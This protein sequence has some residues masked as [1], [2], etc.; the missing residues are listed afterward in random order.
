MRDGPARGATSAA[1]LRSVSRER[2]GDGERDG[3]LPAIGDLGLYGQRS[4][5]VVSLVLF[6]PEVGS[7]ATI[8]TRAEGTWTEW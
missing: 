3:A 2:A 7:W 1:L 8:L 5:K 6:L 4:M